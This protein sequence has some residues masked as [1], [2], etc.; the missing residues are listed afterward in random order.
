MHDPHLE[1]HRCLVIDRLR[2]SMLIGILN[3]EKTETQEVVVSLRLYIPEHGR[4][5]STDIADYI[6][7]ADVV[8]RVRALAAEG[9]IPLVE[10]FAE[11][12]ADIAL[13]DPRVARV[14][15]DVRKTEI[16]PDCDGVGVTIERTRHDL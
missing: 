14:V 2:L 16:I 3:S 6:S 8:E 1:G 5:V 10:N 15:I 7:Y 12:I 13:A 11:Q 4:A 9:H